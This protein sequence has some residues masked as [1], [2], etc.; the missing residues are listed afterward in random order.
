VPYQLTDNFLHWDIDVE[1]VMI[2]ETIADNPIGTFPIAERVDMKE[3]YVYGV[4]DAA[5]DNDDV[6][7]AVGQ[8]RKSNVICI[9]LL[10]VTALLLSAAVIALSLIFA[11]YTKRHNSRTSLNTTPLSGNITV[12]YAASLKSIMQ[13]VIN[14]KYTS[15]YNIGVKTVADASG[16]LAN[17]LKAGEIADIIITADG[18][19]SDSLLKATL[20]GTTRTVTT[21]YTNWASTE[22]GIGYNTESTYADQFNSISNGSM[23]WY[24]VLDP[25]TMRIG[26]TDPDLDPKGLCI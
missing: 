6:Q 23:P 18:K 15:T 11:D 20:P 4:I 1:E 22:L 25:A 2:G 12:Y 19:I 9:A 17:S 26:R 8:P 13:E 3:N 7:H 16:K 5:G 21:W 14:P 24:Q 10:S